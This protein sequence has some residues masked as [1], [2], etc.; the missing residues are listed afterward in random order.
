MLVEKIYL[1]QKQFI[2]EFLG[3]YC[4]LF[5]GT[6]AIIIN[7]VTGGV[8]TKAGIA[9]A[10]G[11]IVFLMIILFGEVSGAHLNPAVTLGLWLAGRFP[12]KLIMAYMISQLSG[13]VAASATLLALFPEHSTLGKTVPSGSSLES[14]LVEIALTAMLMWVILSSTASN[15]RKKITIASIIGTTI[16]LAAF[17]VGPVSGASMNPA[18]SLGPAL[19]LWQLDAQWIYL[20]G[21]LLG[22][23]L[24][25][26]L[27]RPT[28][29]R[30]GERQ[31]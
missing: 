2:A 17:L 8:V 22:A 24:G 6:G 10:F 7:D 31:K 13:A 1:K 21:P 25:V 23:A 3:T 30:C 26:Q 12:G 18:R 9:V 5:V 4:L 19:M 28:R 20:A 14:L 11:L 16:A 29:D 15:K 27:F